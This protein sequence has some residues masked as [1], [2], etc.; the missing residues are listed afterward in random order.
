MDAQVCRDKLASLIAEE[1]RTLA[2]LE[3]MLTREY[4]VLLANDVDELEKTSDPRQERIRVLAGVEEERRALCRANGQTADLPGLERLLR[5]CDPG[6]SLQPAWRACAVLATRCRE[7]NVRNGAL[8]NS[9]LKRVSSVLGIITGAAASDHSQTYGPRGA[10][11]ANRP[12]GR[13][14]GEA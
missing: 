8:V 3:Q 11:G 10:Y 4:D 14:L 6:L 12:T 2:D 9:R 13:V 5:W 7:L 1:S